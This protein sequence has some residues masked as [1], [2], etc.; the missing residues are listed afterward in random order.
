MYK[1][2]IETIKI[3]FLIMISCV[4]ISTPALAGEK[5]INTS[6][7]P[8]IAPRYTYINSASSMLT[9]SDGTATIK[10]SVQKTPSGEN[11]SL[12][13]ILQ[14]KSGFTWKNIKSWSDSSSTDPSVYVSQKYTVSKGEYRVMTNYSVSGT[15]GTESGTAY[16]KTVEYN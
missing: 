1:K 13:C 16:S 14:K 8:I 4:L 2:A 11:I 3:C 6:A 9:I 5:P 10:G 12:T 7:I 15:N